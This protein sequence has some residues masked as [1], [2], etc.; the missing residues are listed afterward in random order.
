MKVSLT[1]SLLHG[2]R[3]RHLSS[4]DASLLDRATALQDARVGSGTPRMAARS[5]SAATEFRRSRRFGVVP[6]GCNGGK[7]P[8]RPR[9]KAVTPPCSV[10]ALQDA[11]AGSEAPSRQE[12]RESAVFTFLEIVFS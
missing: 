9:G 5:W 4:R 6:G 1:L 12:R 3:G 2:V 10:T 11:G 8:A 7:L